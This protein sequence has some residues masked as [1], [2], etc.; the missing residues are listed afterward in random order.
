MIT[1]F[2]N[3]F[4]L[5]SPLFIWVE[6]FGFLNRDKFFKKINFE[7]IESLDIK[8]Y[9]FFYISKLLYLFWILIGCFSN[10]YLFF[11]ILVS[12]GILRSLIFMTKNKLIIN[13]FE[14]INPIF[15][16]I[17]IIFILYRVFFQ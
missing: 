14:L 16:S 2:I 5:M 11:L 12:I 6:F 13:T 15:S 3:L 7:E 8:T 9:F 1:F 10:Q 4:Y 17:I